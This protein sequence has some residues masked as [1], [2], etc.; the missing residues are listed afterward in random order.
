MDGSTPTSR[1]RD[2][3]ARASID[4]AAAARRLIVAVGFIAALLGIAAAAAATAWRSPILPFL[5]ACCVFPAGAVVILELRPAVIAVWACRGIG[6]QR[7][8]IRR[9]RRHL[10]A[11]PETRHPL[12]G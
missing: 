4:H 3:A 7:R 11:L 2:T 6:T 5:E 1:S 8:A 9:F 10:D 12:D